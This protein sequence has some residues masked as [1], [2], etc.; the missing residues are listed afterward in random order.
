MLNSGGGVCWTDYQS[1]VVSV[2]VLLFEWVITLAA[3][4]VAMVTAISTY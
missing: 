3:D 1:G 2:S 4:Q